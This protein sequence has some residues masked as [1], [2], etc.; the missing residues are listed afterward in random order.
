VS[1]KPKVLIAGAGIGGLTAAAFLLK[2]GYPVRVFEQAP[3]LGEIGAGIH[4]SA[5]GIKMFCHLGLAD[6]IEKVGVK[7][8]AY[9][10]RLF[11]SGEVIQTFPLGEEHHRLHGAPYYLFHRA[12][13]HEV[14]VGAVRKLD[15]DA[16]HLS[17]TVESFE[18][19]GSTV[20]LRLTDGRREEGDILIGA[21]GIKSVVREQVLGKTEA[22][23][24]GNAAWRILVP[25]ERL[26]R[27]ATDVVMTVWVGPG[28]H[29]VVYNARSDLVCFV[30]SVESSAWREEGWTV[31]CDWAQMRDDFSAWH[32]EVREII[33]N[34]DRDECYRWGLFIRS[35]VDHWSQG[36]VT[37]LGDAA[38][39]TLPFLA[40]GAVMAVEDGVVL[41]RCLNACDS[42]EEALDLYQRNR[43]PR[44][45]RIIAESTD[46]ARLFHL[47]TEEG[48]RE[49][50]AERELGAERNQWLYNY[51]ALSV[52]LT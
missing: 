7:P 37:L 5:N 52:A 36:H 48:L 41:T 15:P 8:R 26:S 34:A 14:L 10:F 2:S 43:I 47:A 13:L 9:V 24:T 40:Q 42:I 27:D 6:A 51:D 44:T 17:S 19:K 46:N 31:K 35:K 29:A 18:Q 22:H 30:G 20:T 4:M 23:Y 21:D 32:P 1:V 28:A 11:Q 39:A 3:E 45:S 16:I 25:T 49:A 12:D 38:H 33:E 50:F